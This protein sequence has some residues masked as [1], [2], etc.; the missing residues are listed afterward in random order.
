M[1]RTEGWDRGGMG[2]E[3]GSINSST[4]KCDLRCQNF[5]LKFSTEMI[6]EITENSVDAHECLE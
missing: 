2:K 5:E 6:T 4:F 3:Y 1:V